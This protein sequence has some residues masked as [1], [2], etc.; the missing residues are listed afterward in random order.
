[1]L[2]AGNSQAD[3]ITSAR[4]WTEQ[5]TA[6]TGLTPGS[7]P[8][9]TS[10]ITFGTGSEI[11]FNL[12]SS[13]NAGG[14][15]NV[16]DFLNS[17]PAGAGWAV[18]AAVDVMRLSDGAARTVG[19][20]FEFTGSFTTTGTQAVSIFHDDGIRGTIDSI[21]FADLVPA[22]GHS[23]P[24]GTFTGTHTFDLFY[25]ECC[26]LPATLQFLIGTRE[27]SNT[28]TPEPASLALLGSALVGFGVWRRR[29]RTS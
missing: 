13:A 24:L 1:M 11:S 9:V 19:T 29:R 17:S 5:P 20:I 10:P 23:T 28:P 8:G 6:L 18:P 15:G 26:T 16:T 4:V 14:N 25:G 2:G 7:P 22:P 27:V 12:L 3:V 21:A